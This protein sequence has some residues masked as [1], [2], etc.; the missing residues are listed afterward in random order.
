MQMSKIDI[1]AIEQARRGAPRHRL[2]PRTQRERRTGY[3]RLPHRL[4]GLQL[5]RSLRG[6]T[7]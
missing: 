7:G 3:Q 6:R 5:P 1:A 2:D 4:G